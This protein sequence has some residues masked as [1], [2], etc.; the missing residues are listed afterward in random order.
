M[1]AVLANNDQVF[2]ISGTAASND[3][4]IILDVTLPSYI[5]LS[6]T[7]SV[8]SS[9]GED[10]FGAAPSNEESKKVETIAAAVASVGVSEKNYVGTSC[11]RS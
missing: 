11:Q 1:K 2:I 6:Y 4:L 5:T 3:R 7:Y 10:S 9:S 8:K